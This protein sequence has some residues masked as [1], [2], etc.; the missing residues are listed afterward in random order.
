M[1]ASVRMTVPSVRRSLIEVCFYPHLS[2]FPSTAFSRL[3]WVMC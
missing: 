3:E 1:M 2:T